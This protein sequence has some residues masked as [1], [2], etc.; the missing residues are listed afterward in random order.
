[1]KG[2]PFFSRSGQWQHLPSTVAFITAAL[3][4][5]G[6]EFTWK[7]PGNDWTTASSW[8]G[9]SVP[10]TG[11][12]S[13]STRIQIGTSGNAVTYENRLIYSA[14]QGDTIFTVGNSNRS[15]L[16]GNSV[17]GNM[18]IS[19][20]TFTS[21]TATDGMSVNGGSGSLYITGGT[22]RNTDGTFELVYNNGTSLLQ[23]DSG[24]FEVGTMNFQSQTATTAN[25]T[26]QLNGGTLSVG[27][28]NSNSASGSHRVLLNGGTVASRTNATWADR[29][30]TTWELQQ[31]STFNIAH[32]VTFGEAL[33]GT[34]GFNKTGIGNFT[35]TGANS[36]T[37]LTNVGGGILTVGHDT[38]LGAVGVGNTT[39][40]SNQA[41]VV[42]A[43]NVTVTGE[44]ISIVGTGGDGNI[45]AL[46]AA[47]NATATWAGAITL[48]TGDGSG[49]TR[50]GARTGGN[51]IIAGN[52]DGSSVPL[53]IRNEGGDSTTGTS[54]D[55]TM[56]T[57]QGGYTG[58]VLRLYQGVVKLGASERIQ[59][60]AGIVFG[61][62]VSGALR[63]R[64]DLNGFNE[65]VS[66]ISVDVTIG[67][68]NHEITNSSATTRSTFTLNSGVDT[69][70]R[71]FSGVVTGN[72]DIQKLGSNSVTF[73]AV[74]TYV[75]NTAVNAGTFVVADGGALNGGGST[76][77]ASGATFSL[78]GTYLYNIGADGDSNQI[79][80]AGTVNLNGIF[81][82]NLASA[83]IAD[84]NEWTLVA[85]TGSVDWNGLRITS[86]AGDFTRQDGTWTLN[87]QDN[88]WTFNESDGVLSLTTIPE[89]GPT[90]L[91]LTGAAASVLRRRRR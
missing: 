70:A 12:E 1:M 33:S 27:L 50:I 16:I 28:F 5:Q 79:S 11:G 63:Q 74:N 9:N 69:T 10:V 4:A 14:A 61:H 60:T 41:R 36:H 68:A 44:A 21:T 49:D 91:L 54:F 53:G 45:G 82:L 51:L 88:L 18:E 85:A 34:G 43:N 2:L 83:A 62:N 20:G 35:L 55:N 81:H 71:S 47:S 15:L 80:G 19:G 29:T 17:A 23:I 3:S 46:Q 13:G 58:T 65:T 90:T 72:L 24:A 39:R 6:A 25:G 31:T 86:T 52:I 48:A 75:G 7:G 64:L 67:S 76:N 37:G 26:I 89:P 22:Y 73:S 42:L 57:L 8:V 30:N 66:H 77:V 59:D 32:S 40:V 38:A 78:L 87:E 56:V 84:G